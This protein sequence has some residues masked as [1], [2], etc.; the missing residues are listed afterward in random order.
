MITRTDLFICVATVF[1]VVLI[2]V[3]IYFLLR[4]RKASRDTWSDIVG[5][6]TEVDRN[7][8]AVV[9]LDLVDETGQPRE[10]GGSEIEP[11]SL[12][13]LVGGLNGLE[14]LEKNC[15]VLIDLAAYVQRL[16]PEALVVAEQLRLNAREIQWHVGRLRGAAQTGNL[17]SSF[18]LYA[19]RAV[20][21]YY[22]MT[23]HLLE[24]Y[25]RGNLA[26]FAQLEAVL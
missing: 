13:D 23:R 15:E 26:E 12:W 19:Q 4:I 22:L 2:G 11:E 18:P 5:R 9:A 6:L 1:L 17:I 24:L 8:I 10:H 25:E 21:T 14:I 3:A 7:R 20:A 16:H